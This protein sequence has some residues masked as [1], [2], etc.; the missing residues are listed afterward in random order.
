MMKNGLANIFKL[1]M[2]LNA[3]NIKDTDR[4]A[5]N[6]IKYEEAVDAINDIE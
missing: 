4:E 3:K 6:R 5:Y 1:I 2:S